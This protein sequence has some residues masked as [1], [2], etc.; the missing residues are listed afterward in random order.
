MLRRITGVMVHEVGG[1][2][3]AILRS[4]GQSVRVITYTRNAT[5]EI[6][7]RLG[8]N[9]FAAVSTIHAFCWELIKGFDADIRDA[10]LAK[11][12]EKLADARAYAKS[13]KRRVRQ[14]PGEVRRD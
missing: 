5:A 14:R 12:A 13:K 11:N 6:V 8:E 3:A 1:Q 9:P 7:G 2:H 10:L 4:R